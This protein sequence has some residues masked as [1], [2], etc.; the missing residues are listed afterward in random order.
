MVCIVTTHVGAA[1]SAWQT[2][3]HVPAPEFSQGRLES[4]YKSHIEPMQAQRTTEKSAKAFHKLMHEL[5]LRPPNLSPTFLS[6]PQQET[7]LLLISTMINQVV[8]SAGQRK[9]N[10]SCLCTISL[11]S[12]NIRG[13]F[14]DVATASETQ[15]DALLTTFDDQQLTI[16]GHS[17]FVD[18]PAVH[19]LLNHSDD[20]LDAFLAHP[21][22]SQSTLAW[23]NGIVKIRYAALIRELAKKENGWHFSAANTS[24]EQLQNFRIEDMAIQMKALAPELWPT[25]SA[26]GTCSGFCSQPVPEHK[27]IGSNSK[28]KGLI[29]RF[30]YIST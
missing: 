6:P 29:I 20:V 30:P 12:Q 22:T 8:R 1:L 24:A 18:H 7:S 9:F 3:V 16:P 28:Q 19:D 11:L 23:A 25:G 5:Y 10:D 14:P 21:R 26:C 2:G 4:T 27:Y 13:G 15:L 17:A